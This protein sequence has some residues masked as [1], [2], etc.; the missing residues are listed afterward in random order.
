MCSIKKFTLLF[1]QEEKFKEA[2]RAL[3]SFAYYSPHDITIKQSM[4]FYKSMKQLSK[5]DLLPRET[6]DYVKP[7][8]VII[9]H[10]CIVQFPAGAFC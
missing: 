8:K 10:C 9:Y 7:I 3:S 4:S 6:F 5:E 2:A 1:K